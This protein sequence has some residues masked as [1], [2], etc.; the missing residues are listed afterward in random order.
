MTN[1]NCRFF[2]IFL[3]VGIVRDLA[4][5][6][7]ITYLIVLFTVR[8]QFEPT[9]LP[10]EHRFVESRGGLQDLHRISTSTICSFYWFSIP[11]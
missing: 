9:N 1:E 8:F 2:L 4:A 11:R 5:L 7:D 10:N 3:I 6:S